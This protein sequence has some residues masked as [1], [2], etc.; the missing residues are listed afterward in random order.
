MSRWL[1]QAATVAILALPLA[2]HAQTPKP[3]TGSLTVAFGAEATV[4]DPTRSA[5]G[6]DQYYIGQMF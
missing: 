4:L 1:Q 3:A 2:T 5:A 6:V